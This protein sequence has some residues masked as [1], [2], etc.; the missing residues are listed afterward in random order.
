VETS[1]VKLREQQAKAA[2]LRRPDLAEEA[3]RRIALAEIQ[4]SALKSQ[5]E[6][7]RGQEQKLG[8]A[9]EHLQARIDAPQ[10]VGSGPYA[11]AKVLTNAYSLRAWA[12]R[13]ESQ[14]LH[15]APTGLFANR[16]QTLCGRPVNRVLSIFAP[17]EATC[18]ECKR[19]W[20]LAT[21]M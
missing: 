20:E 13:S 3:G 18:K 10:S 14:T 5:L 21:G 4:V 9:A 12:S 7:L 6:Q 19:R 2:E 1:V 16:K 17:G 11:I 8:E 15:I